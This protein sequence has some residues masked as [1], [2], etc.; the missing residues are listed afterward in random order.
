MIPFETFIKKK[1]ITKRTPDQALKQSLLKDAKERIQQ[2]EIKELKNKYKFEQAYESVRE[3][4]DAHLAGEGYKTYSHEAAIAF[5]EHKALITNAEHIRVDLCRK[6]RNNTKYYG[7]EENDEQ[8]KELT[9]FLKNL[10]RRVIE[11]SKK[12]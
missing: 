4:A 11:K 3:L 8:Y 6:T 12:R 9:S 2:T 7:E 1:K 10:F 5:L